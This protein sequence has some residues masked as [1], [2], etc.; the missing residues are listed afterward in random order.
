MRSR[1]QLIVLGSVLSSLL[2]CD[3]A[4][5]PRP[6]P[7][8]PDEGPLP[9]PVEVCIVESTGHHARAT[10]TPHRAG[11]WD[12]SMPVDPA[13]LNWMDSGG[14][15]VTPPVDDITRVPCPEGDP[16]P[17]VTPRLCGR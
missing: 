12:R 17:L 6:E 11:M 5:E 7:T 10:V 2:G 9:P 16:I 4:A 8:R 14:H 1:W 15:C 3:T 13:A